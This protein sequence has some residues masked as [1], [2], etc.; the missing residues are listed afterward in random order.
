MAWSE[1]VRFREHVTKILKLVVMA[2]HKSAIKH[3]RQS[4]KRRT[5]NRS[6]KTAVRS[7]LKNASAA[8]QSGNKA[9][10]E[11]LTREAESMMSK[12]TKKGLFHRS[13]LSRKISRLQSQASKIAAK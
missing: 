9:E 3:H 7:A 13:T 10:A 1:L 12:A 4:L 6:A 5:H 2:N 11:K 8:I